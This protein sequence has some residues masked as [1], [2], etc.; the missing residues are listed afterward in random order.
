LLESLLSE[1]AAVMP[2]RGGDTVDLRWRLLD[3]YVLFLGDD[4]NSFSGGLFPQH[5]LL[6]QFYVCMLNLSVS[7]Y[8]ISEG[9]GEGEVEGEES[10]K[11]TRSMKTLRTAIA[12]GLLA[13]GCLY[14]FLHS[15]HIDKETADIE[16]AVSAACE[17][18]LTN[19]NDLP[20]P[21]PPPAASLEH[22]QSYPPANNCAEECATFTDSLLSHI[23]GNCS[24]TREGVSSFFLLNK[25]AVISLWKVAL[26]KC[27]IPAGH[28]ERVAYDTIR[29]HFATAAQEHMRICRGKIDDS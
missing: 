13:V 19:Q 16:A 23:I 26:S 7:V 12:L 11:K 20:L 6:L 1:Y 25:T 29:L 9:D 27:S 22:E 4:L 5:K 10:R 2:L 15:D 8:S 24:S 18:C 3:R 14:A 17:L 28:D 21:S